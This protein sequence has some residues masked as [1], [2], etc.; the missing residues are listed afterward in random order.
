MRLE[1][2][3]RALLASLYYA[4]RSYFFQQ[5]TGTFWDDTETKQGVHEVMFLA[6]L[7]AQQYLTQDTMSQTVTFVYD[8][9]T[10][11]ATLTF[12]FGR[13][14]SGGEVDFTLLRDP[15]PRDEGPPAPPVEDAEGELSPPGDDFYEPSEIP[16]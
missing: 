12:Q 10:G 2:T 13:W 4:A 15:E 3:A 6:L 8:K 16:F 14:V 1:A 9:D 11:L 7:S 5:R